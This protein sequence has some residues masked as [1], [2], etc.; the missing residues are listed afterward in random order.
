MK[1]S[2]MILALQHL[3]TSFTEKDQEV[4]IVWDGELKEIDNIV[5]NAESRDVQIITGF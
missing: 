2:K 1:V 3:K 5:Y 4:E